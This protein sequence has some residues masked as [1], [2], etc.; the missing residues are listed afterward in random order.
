MNNPYKDRKCSECADFRYDE[1]IGYYCSDDSESPWEGCGVK[2]G[3]VA[4]EWFAEKESEV[5][6]G[7]E[8]S[9]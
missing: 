3:T 8:Q 7:R 6:N 2:E 1:E 5:T 9:Y 4:C